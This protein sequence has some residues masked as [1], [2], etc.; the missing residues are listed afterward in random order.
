MQLG[1][2]CA[3]QTR[4]IT[5]RPLLFQSCTL[6]PQATGQLPSALPL[7]RVGAQGACT[8]SDLHELA[9]VRDRAADAKVVRL[10]PEQRRSAHAQLL[11]DELPQARHCF[12]TVETVG[13]E[14][15]VEARGGRAWRAWPSP[16]AVL[17]L[18]LRQELRAHSRP[19]ATHQANAT[20]RDR[21]PE[22]V[23]LQSWYREPAQHLPGSHRRELCTASGQ[24][25]AGQFAQGRLC[26]HFGR[27]ALAGRNMFGR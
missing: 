12:E 1:D 22:A 6:E 27:S 25:L 17:C 21:T 20:G 26:G 2:A 8:Q 10:C 19:V 16:G 23:T 15:Q 4:G 9:E 24:A 7:G 11:S 14:D 5:R 3:A 13:A 18:S